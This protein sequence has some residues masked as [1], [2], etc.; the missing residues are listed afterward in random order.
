MKIIKSL[1]VVMGITALI[2]CSE[3][4]TEPELSRQDDNPNVHS[5]PLEYDTIQEAIDSADVED[6][7]LVADGVYTGDGNRDITFSQKYIVLKSENGP[8]QTILDLQGTEENYHFGFSF[9]GKADSAIIDGF[10]IR[11][12]YNNQGTAIACLTASP[13]VRNC[14]MTGNT[15]TISG[16]AIRCKSYLSTPIFTNCTMANNSSMAGGGLFIIAGASPIMENCIIAFNTGGGAVFSS[17]GTSIPTFT[18]SNI[19]EN[20]GGDWSDAI[21]D[22]AGTN[23]NMSTDPKFCNTGDADYG[24]LAESPCLPDNND[25]AVLIG[26]ADE[27]CMISAK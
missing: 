20:T 16:G 14:I 6:T 5:V 2:G 3:S 4:S 11:N 12:G 23:G 27:T 19:Y 7:V 24:L 21:A 22:Q 13:T 10:T 1:V 15:G 9:D 26:A 25:C 18:C 17:D 8:L